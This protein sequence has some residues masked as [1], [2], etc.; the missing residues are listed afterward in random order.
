M[1]RTNHTP[2]TIYPTPGP[3]GA[4]MHIVDYNPD[5]EVARSFGWVTARCGALADE[6]TTYDA[7]Y[8]CHTPEQPGWLDYGPSRRCRRCWRRAS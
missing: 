5:D 4:C 8:A 7:W 6:R 3:G 1:A 2:G